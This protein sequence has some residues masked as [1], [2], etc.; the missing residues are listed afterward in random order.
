MALSQAITS[1]VP[2]RYLIQN[3]TGLTLWYWAQP[4]VGGGGLGE[5]EGYESGPP[6][7][8]HSHTDSCCLFKII[9]IIKY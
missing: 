3:L 2:Q 9:C 1:R 6:P 8:T 7:F 5:G 4:G